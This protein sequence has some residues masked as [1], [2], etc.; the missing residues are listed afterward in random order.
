MK[1]VIFGLTVSSAWGNGH[2]TLWRGLLRALARKG[3]EAVFFE[4]DVPY[5]AQ[6][7]D[8]ARGDGWEL[9]V[10]PSFDTVLP[11]ARRAL[12]DADVAM[13]SSYCPDA[14]RA[15]DL[16]L[17]SPG[18]HVFYDMDTPITLAALERG[19]EVPYLPERGLADFDLVLSYTGGAAL[20]A[21]ATKLGARRTAPLYGWV[22]GDAHHPSEPRPEYACDL[23]YLGTY[24]ADR[25]A[26]VQKLFLDV[27]A[28]THQRFLLGGPLYP[29]DMP[30]PKNLTWLPHV[31]PPEH[32]AFYASSR[33]TLNVTRGTM[34]KMGF[35]P[36]GRL[37]EAAACNVPI[38]SDDWTGLEEFF[39]P[40]RE[41]V[42][43]R[44]GEDVISALTMPRTEL[45]S[46]AHR[47]R[48]RTL[49]EHTAD[50]RA[51]RLISLVRD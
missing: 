34:A 24:A 31:P 39:E 22:D 47:A 7:R 3:H 27:A 10:Y 8:L 16:V 4:K 29:D 14:R 49:A 51:A 20:D 25:Q 46:I 17:A 21:L 50:H 45:A 1:L 13:V 33:A 28:R 35:C 12:D 5:Y 42:V 23:S 48:S 32:P 9:V 36:S 6:Q 43:A 15:T 38:I 44:T 18:R 11:M 2:A 26:A 40:G 41:I 37:F 30:R 19:E